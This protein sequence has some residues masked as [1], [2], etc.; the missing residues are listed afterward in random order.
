MNARV[1]ALIVGAALLI[2]GVIGLLVPASASSNDL[3]GSNE[4]V[5]CGVPIAGGDTSKAEE[6]DKNL[7]NAVAN[8]A[9]SLGL[10][11]V[12]NAT[13]QTHFVAACNSAINTRLAWTI[14]LAIV[15]ALVLV[16]SFAVGRRTRA[17]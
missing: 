2:A 5:S 15:G 1:L 7:G 13:P 4:S 10:P 6:K 11:G 9:N 8:G 12:A 17:V 14:P 3:Q 16:G